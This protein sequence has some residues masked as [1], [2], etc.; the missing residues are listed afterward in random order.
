MGVGGGGELIPNMK[1][2]IFTTDVE[3]DGDMLTVDLRKEA[4]GRHLWSGARTA[5]A[6]SESS[7]FPP[8][9]SLEEENPING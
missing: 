5:P 4:I 9:Q 2:H 1:H 7:P 8:E 6:K 3:A